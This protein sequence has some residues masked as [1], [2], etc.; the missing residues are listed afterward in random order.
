M[1]VKKTAAALLTGV[2]A[3][4]LAGCGSDSGAPAGQAA[5]QGQKPQP[6]TQEK[7]ELRISWWGG[8]ARAELYRQ[9]LDNFE[10]TYPHIKVNREFADFNPYWDKLTTQAA[11]GNAPDVVHMHLTKIADYAK[12]NQ[13]L[14]LDEQIQAKEIDLSDFS[15]DIVNTGKIN[16]KTYMVTIGNSS[17]SIIYNA[18]LF[19]RV[20]VTPPADNWTWDQFAD[21]AIELKKA[22]NRDDFWAIEGPGEGNFGQMLRSKGKDLYTP[23]GKL[24]YTKED[25]IEFMQFWEKLRQ[26]GAIPPAA[27]QAELGGK[28]FEQSMFAKGMAGMTFKATNQLKIFQQKSQDQLEI[29]RV[30][31]L[32]GGKGGETVEGAYM[33]IYSKSKHPKEA[34]LLINYFINDPEAA[35]IFKAEHGPVGSKKMNEV[36]KPML[37]PSS[38]KVIDF[39]DKVAPHLQ[40]ASTPPI[41]GNEISKQ[42]KSA[43]EVVAFGKNPIEKAVDDYF[44]EAAKTLK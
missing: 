5:S 40:I 28:E 7:V 13:L 27:T 41:G 44:A 34:A 10:K 21:K 19:K 2:L 16:G 29:T 8:E 36:L 33:S 18:D 37:D 42:F 32:P 31:T 43:I 38:I 39:M 9:I 30:P 12:R 14:A 25:M 1:K 17:S 22:V 20:G 35:K 24:G 15:P 23:D 4:G 3:A 6:Q 26:A 11:G